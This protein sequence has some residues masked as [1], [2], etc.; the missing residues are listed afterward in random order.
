MKSV[1]DARF[2]IT[3]STAYL[4]F[5][6]CPVHPLRVLGH[7]V[8]IPECLYPHLDFTRVVQ[9]T[10]VSIHEILDDGEVVVRR[11]VTEDRVVSFLEVGVF[12][13]EIGEGIP[14]VLGSNDTRSVVA[15]GSD[16]G[17]SGREGV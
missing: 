15:D 5:L 3:S 4:K 8:D 1:S 2:K 10:T 9:N 14:L 6:V 16:S 12:L 13:D 7:T 11:R 17:T